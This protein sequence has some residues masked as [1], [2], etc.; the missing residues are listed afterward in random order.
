ML[1]LKWNGSE[2]WAEDPETIGKIRQNFFGEHKNARVFLNIEEA[3]YLLQ[4][5][6]AECERDGKKIGFNDLASA[7]AKA[8]PRL[9]IRYNAFRDWRDRGLVAKRFDKIQGLGAETAK[10]YPSQK[11][12][13][14]K[15]NAKIVWYPGSLFSILEDEKLG[16][17]LFN[18]YWFGQ[19][20]IYKQDRG[21]LLK[22]NFFETIFLAKHFG[23]KVISANTGTEANYKNI[24]ED[25]I[26]KREYTKQLYEVYEEWRLHDFVVKTGFKFG[27]HFRIYFPGASPAKKGKWIHSKHVLHIFPKE[28]RLLIS[29]WSRAVRVAHGVKKTFILAIPKMD[30]SDYIN[31]PLDYLAYRRKKHKGNLIRETPKDKPRYLLEAVSEDDHIGGIELATLLK[32][33]SD[34]KLELLLS[35]SD[36]ESAITY[37][38][39]KK[40]NIPDSKYEYYEIEWMKP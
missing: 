26:K 30:E 33:S 37:Y 27:S 20:G 17:E 3:L 35:I 39:L 9:F 7:Y 1:Q 12:Q 31:Y 8:E 15:I 21:T 13:I 4:F 25:V 40:V 11:M 34:Q 36:R 38:V 18:T 23:V 24:M 10:K 28:E 29:E 6:N 22:L 16:K 2:I 19:F 32:R 5:Q 14:K